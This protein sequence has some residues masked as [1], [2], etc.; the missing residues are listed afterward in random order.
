MTGAKIPSV[1][2]DL[3]ESRIK[4]EPGSLGASPAALSDD[5]IYE[6]TGDLDFSQAQIVWLMRLP[7]SLWQNWASLDDDE[8]IELGTVRVEDLGQDAKGDSKQKMTLLL[9]N[10]T[11]PNKNIPKEY[12]M[13]VTNSKSSNVYIFSEK[14]PPKSNKL[15][16]AQRPGNEAE[17]GLG[18]SKL[19]PH[20]RQGGTKK[21]KWNRFKRW[22]PFYR[23]SI[24]KHTALAG[25]VKHE[26][27][28]LPVEN[29]EYARIMAERNAEAAKPKRETKFLG[30]L[31][32]HQANLLAPGTLGS[33]AS[34]ADFIRTGAPPRAQKQEQK[35]A[36]IPQNELLDLIYDC[37]RQY[38]FWSL[39]ALKGELNQPEAYLKQTLEMIADLVKTGRF[40]NTWTLKPENKIELYD[41]A[42]EGKDELAPDD[43]SGFGDDGGL[44]S[45]VGGGL[46][47]DFDE[48]DD[49]DNVRME[50]V[51]PS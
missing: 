7:P 3:D 21:P 13:N 24:P 14:D 35:A 38:N 10:A 28:C 18:S 37:F 25:I 27:N 16:T 46:G 48:E 50:D 29:A 5:D 22:Q 23:R 39:K 43:A 17:A 30:D 40:A 15:K 2:V 20:N 36:R 51:L 8:R 1:K 4:S 31:G 19:T 45:G 11:K 6:D 44:E 49:D 41:A 47:D 9:N 33:N 32:V 26:I 12:R 42:V 34:F